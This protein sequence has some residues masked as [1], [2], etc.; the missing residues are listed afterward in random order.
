MRRKPRGLRPLWA[1]PA[2]KKMIIFNPENGCSGDMIIASMI[3]LGTRGA[4]EF[5]QEILE[6]SGAEGTVSAEK[7]RD[8]TRLKVKIERDI[9]EF[10][11]AYRKCLET[12]MPVPVKSFAKRTIEQMIAFEREIHGKHFHLHELNSAD[13]LI[14]IFTAGYC[15]NEHGFGAKS[16]PIAVGSGLVK[17]A[18][19]LMENPPPLGKKFLETRKF[20]Y[21]RK[22]V[23]F[24]IATPTGIAIL[25]SLK[26]AEKTGDKKIRTGRGYGNSEIAGHKNCLTVH[27]TRETAE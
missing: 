12:E 5:A 17:T 24:E 8:G 11:S 14:D 15:L 18:H 4:C 20:P 21:F 13:T 23:A 25:T 2:T 27:E 19:G 10:E 7:Y 9:G 6:T 26:P 16:M 1:P 3:D 22:E